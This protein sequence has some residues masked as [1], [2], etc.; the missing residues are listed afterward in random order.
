M[1]VS[2]DVDVVLAIVDLATVH[3]VFEIQICT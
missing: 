1:S 3:F 2:D